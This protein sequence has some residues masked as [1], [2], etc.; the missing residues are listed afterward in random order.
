MLDLD[1]DLDQPE[2]SDLL[3]EDGRI[4]AVGN[5]AQSAR[6]STAVTTIDARGKLI[7][8]GLINAH[9]HSHDVMLRGLFEQLPLDAW[10][11][12]SAPHNYPR[13]PDEDI[14]LR[15]RLGAAECLLN[16]MTTVQDMVSI[17]DADRDQLD[18]I[19]RAYSESGIR[20]VLA[21]QYSDRA[22]VDCV[23]FWRDLPE[24]VKAQLPDATDT[25]ALQALIGE[26]VTSRHDRL[27]WALGPSAPQRCSDALLRWTADL[28]RQHRLQVFTHAYEARSQAVLARMEYPEGSLVTHIDAMG[29]LNERLTIAHG[30]WIGTPEIKRLGAARANLACNPISNMKL[31]NG[32]A[33]IVDYADAGTNIGL[34]CDNCS[35][36]D[37]QNIFQSMKMFALF[38]GLYSNAG[39][40]GAA[41]EAFRAATVGGARAL[42][43]SNELGLLRPGYRADLV[44]IDLD[45]ASYRPLNS[46][47]RQL[48]YSESGKGVHTVMVDGTIVVSGGKLLTMSETMLKTEAEIARKRL[49]PDTRQIQ[50][51]ND[52]F[53]ADILSAYEKA[54]RY[55]LDFD[56]RLLRRQ[57]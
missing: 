41:R 13:P 38:W 54:D 30:V 27:H 48:V 25:T 37:A 7:I 36:N 11:L 28:S 22:A 35:G 32:F 57:P 17:V 56:R 1:G 6:R 47:V 15:T 45:D 5:N 24:P 3:I 46:A 26:R 29:L 49:L 4:V 19:Q 16:G 51:R 31:L 8:P 18:S 20:V 39:D 33:P 9:Y 50:I 53:L 2:P 55:P 23:A 14:G 12:Y 34:G 52:R 40:T 21:L 42:G 10:Q 44:M 43:L